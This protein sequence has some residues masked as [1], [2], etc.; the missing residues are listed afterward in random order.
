MN[1]SPLKQE[2]ISGTDLVV[3][4]ELTSGIY[5]GDKGRLEGGNAAFDTC[6][7]SVRGNTR[8]AKMAFEA[9]SRRRGLL[10]LIDKANVLES[11]R[12]WREVVQKNGP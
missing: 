3:Y 10:T 12:L 8:I 2:R 1:R 11:S 6:Y 9:A 5:F 7:Y 4:R